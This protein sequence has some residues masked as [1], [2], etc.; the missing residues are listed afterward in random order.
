MTASAPLLRNA[1][2]HRIDVGHGEPVLLLHGNPDS[3]AMWQPVID[4][5]APTLRCVAPDLPGFGATPAPPGFDYSLEH[6][7]AFVDHAVTQ[8]GIDQPLTL[9]MHDFGGP[10]GMAWAVRHPHK[11]RRIVVNNTLFFSDYRWHFWGRVWR[12]PWL[13]ELSMRLMN[14]WILALE[15][16]RGSPHISDAHLDAAYALMTPSMRRMVLAL[17]RKSDP[18]N[19]RGWEDQLLALT[20]R[21]PTLVLWGERDPYLPRQFADRFG[22]RQIVAVPDAGHWLA[23]EQPQTVA[24]AIRRFIDATPNG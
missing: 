23:V 1:P 7:A 22:A 3:S 4:R 10:Y 13:G 24:D 2:V 14:R 16:R 12:T 15:T 20:Q 21:V 9:V 19:F 6:M 11:V 8:A 18:A 5:L 17:Y